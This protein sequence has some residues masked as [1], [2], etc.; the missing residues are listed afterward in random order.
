MTNSTLLNSFAQ[1][2]TK[3]ARSPIGFV[4]GRMPRGLQYCFPLAEPSFTERLKGLKPAVKG[5]AADNLLGFI[6]YGPGLK[7]IVS[8][9]SHIG[10]NIPSWNVNSPISVEV[11]IYITTALTTSDCYDFVAMTNSATPTGASS[12]P[13][14]L[15]NGYGSSGNTYDFVGTIT[16][17]TPTLPITTGIA[18]ATGPTA[19]GSRVHVVGTWD[20]SSTISI[21]INGALA[22]AASWTGSPTGPGTSIIIGYCDTGIDN[23][24]IAGV[25]QLVNIANVDW[26]PA[27]VMGR[28]TNPFGFLAYSQQP[29]VGRSYSLGVSLSG[30]AQMMTQGS[31]VPSALAS[32]SSDGK[33]VSAIRAS[34]TAIAYITARSGALSSGR[35]PLIAATHLSSL[36]KSVS[37]GQLALPQAGA[38]LKGTLK[39]MSV[40]QATL[41]AARSLSGQ[42]SSVTTGEGTIVRAASLRA[43]GSSQGEG[44]TS[45]AVA[46]HPTGQTLTRG[47]GSAKPLVPAFIRAS[48]SIVSKA[49]GALTTVASLQATGQTRSMGTGRALP[50]VQASL[51][52]RGTGQA[53]GI[54]PLVAV[55]L[56]RGAS[57]STAQGR[58]TIVRV[59]LLMAAGFGRAGGLASSG[60]RA[61]LAAAGRSVAKGLGGLAVIAPL[62]ASGFTRSMGTGRA[63]LIARA[64]LAGQ[65]SGTSSMTSSPTVRA[66]LSAWGKVVA[67]GH[68]FLRIAS[69]PPPTYVTTADFALYPITVTDQALVN[70]LTQD[71]PITALNASIAVVDAEL[72]EVAT[73]D[74]SVT[75][76]SVTDAPG[77]EQ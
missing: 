49:W 18:D 23:G 45:I 35:V 46:A 50:V 43:R 15:G 17:T 20:G 3:P 25:T 40:V 41:R 30:T 58:A 2:W 66:L 53:R 54:V 68:A 38:Q 6:P 56:L 39:G 21:Y 1:G 57:R 55:A 33:S 12:F 70:L 61:S 8:T 32:L 37:E 16:S 24:P 7:T 9:A 36:L 77:W 44:H 29:F 71:S 19:K 42:G 51:Q 34:A 67:F 27:E 64:S 47:R 14:V 62:V 63:A 5:T 4:Q 65:S 28:Y 13:W 11:I 69:K 10:Y 72:V 75:S 52:A 22:K 60:A 73:Q 59:A 31:I 74:Y 76:M 26:T 48:G